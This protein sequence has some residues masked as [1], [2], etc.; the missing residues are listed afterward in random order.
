MLCSAVSTA[1][2][3][4][5]ALSG[6]DADGLRQIVHAL[7]R[8]SVDRIRV[9]RRGNF[10]DFDVRALVPLS[11]AIPVRYRLYSHAP[12]AREMT[13]LASEAQIGGLSQLRSSLAASPSRCGL[14]RDR[15]DHRI[16]AQTPLR[17]ERDRRGGRR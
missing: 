17:S 2:R 1:S 7:L 9:S 3:P 5:D 8:E 11:Q 12:T 16:A 13:E 6:P 14:A 4:T 10:V 15:H